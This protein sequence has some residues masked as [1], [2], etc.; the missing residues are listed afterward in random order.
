MRDNMERVL[1]RD[2]KLSD[3]DYR[4]ESLQVGAQQFERA[5]TRIRRKYWWKN[6]KMMIILAVV[7]L[8]V[9]GIIIAVIVTSVKKNPE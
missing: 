1:E 8:V 7:I 3:L 2:Q 5:T 9:L 6:M 4:A